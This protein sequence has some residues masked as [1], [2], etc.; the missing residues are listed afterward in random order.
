[1]KHEKQQVKFLS[2]CSLIKSIDCTSFTFVAYKRALF[3]AA[4]L[5]MISTYK[6]GLN[7]TC[8]CKFGSWINYK[9]HPYNS[10]NM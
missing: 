4:S 6:C 7:N 8:V 5:V 9:I 3:W 2:V 10:E 1:M